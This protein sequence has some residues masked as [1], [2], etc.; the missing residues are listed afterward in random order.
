[1]LI[2]ILLH[3][4]LFHQECF[5]FEVIQNLSLLLQLSIVFKVMLS[6]HLVDFPNLETLEVQSQAHIMI[7]IR[8]VIEVSIF[9]HY[10][11]LFWQLGDV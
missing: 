2:V 7:F 8:L 3:V 6:I 5:L 9:W 10:R 11:F 4:C 1:M